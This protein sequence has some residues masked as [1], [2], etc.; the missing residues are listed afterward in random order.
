MADATMM[1]LMCGFGWYNTHGIVSDLGV[2]EVTVDVM[3]CLLLCV[4]AVLCVPLFKNAIM[5]L[6]PYVG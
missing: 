6:I 3:V 2:I 5:V 1:M 4:G